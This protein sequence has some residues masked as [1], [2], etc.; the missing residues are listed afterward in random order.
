MINSGL[1]QGDAMSPVL[2]NITLE[3]V[4]RKIPWTQILSLDERNVLLAYSD[5]IVVIG[6]LRD[7]IQITIEELIKIGKDI[8]LIINREK[9]KYVLVKQEGVIIITTT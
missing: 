4:T 3:S 9:T 6:K 2:F 5:D 8:G 7:S 1:K